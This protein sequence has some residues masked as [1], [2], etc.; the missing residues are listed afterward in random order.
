[1]E[2][3]YRKKEGN[4]ARKI[5]RKKEISSNKLNYFSIVPTTQQTFSEIIE[6]QGT[7]FLSI[8]SEYKEEKRRKGEREKERKREREKEKNRER[9]KERKRDRVN[10]RNR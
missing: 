8:F 9:K 7:C 3:S 1:M 2:D 5:E 10:G 6:K 4:K